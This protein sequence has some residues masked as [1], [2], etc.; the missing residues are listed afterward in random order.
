MVCFLP[1]ISLIF[2][3]IA[4]EPRSSMRSVMREIETGKLF[5]DTCFKKKVIQRED[6]SL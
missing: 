2:V 4:I 1:T 5:Q 6:K 3:H